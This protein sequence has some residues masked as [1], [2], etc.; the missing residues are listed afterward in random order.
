[1]QISFNVFLLLCLLLFRSLSSASLHAVSLVWCFVLL[2]AGFSSFLRK[3]AFSFKCRTAKS[4]S[5][6]FFRL[7]KKLADVFYDTFIRFRLAVDVAGFVSSAAAVAVDD[8]SAAA[9]GFW[10]LVCFL[11]CRLIPKAFFDLVR[12]EVDIRSLCLCSSEFFECIS[13]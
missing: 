13:F 5:A 1:M 6:F 2:V 7:P 4:L 10:V 8:G 3:I 9:F 11:E 12:F